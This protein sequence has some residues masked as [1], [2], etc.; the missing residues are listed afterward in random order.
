MDKEKENDMADSEKTVQDVLDEMT[1]EQKKVV[2]YL[3]GA[4]IQEAKKN[5]GDEGEENMKH[6]IFDNSNEGADEEL[7]HDAME[8]I[9]ADAKRY[10]SVKES[11]LEHAAEYG[12]DHIDYLFPDAKTVTN[13]PTFID[14]EQDWVAKV[15]NGVHHTPFSRIKSMFAD[16]TFDFSP[17]GNLVKQFGLLL[18]WA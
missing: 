3:V 9:I 14:R 18:R 2:N 6:S 15:M 10:G 8:S 12:I 7:M 11:F 13:Q 5:T 4:A 1:E 17:E 16:I